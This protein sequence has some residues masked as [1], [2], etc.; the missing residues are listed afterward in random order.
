MVVPP[1]FIEIDSMK[2]PFGYGEEARVSA[3]SNPNSRS[4]STSGA[5]QLDLLR[6]GSVNSRGGSTIGVRS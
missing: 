6:Q 5:T 4:N 2:T 1:Q 3:N